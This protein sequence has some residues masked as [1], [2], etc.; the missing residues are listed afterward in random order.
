MDLKKTKTNRGECKLAIDEVNQL[1]A[2]QWINSKVVNFVSSMN[3]A[4][5][6]TVS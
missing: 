2:F 1:L 6:S 3:D 4:S 5:L